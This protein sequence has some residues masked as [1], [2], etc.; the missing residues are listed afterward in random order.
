M[1]VDPLDA[2]MWNKTFNEAV[3]SYQEALKT[4]A[5]NL[6][7]TV[8]SGMI[9]KKDPVK[10]ETFFNVSNASQWSH[11]QTHLRHIQNECYFR[12]LSFITR[13]TSGGTAVKL[14]KATTI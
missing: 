14:H 1:G 2:T 10:A 6:A 11:K 8:E 5:A 4:K 3:Q 13:I 7:A 12:T 9:P